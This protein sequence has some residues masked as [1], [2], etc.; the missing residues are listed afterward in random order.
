MKLKFWFQKKYEEQKVFN[1]MTGIIF[2]AE[3][4][5]R[6][7]NVLFYDKT[8]VTAENWG[9]LKADIVCVIEIKDLQVVKESNCIDEYIL[10]NL[11]KQ[12]PKWFCKV[13]NGYII[14]LLG[15]KLNK[16]PYDYDS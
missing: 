5:G 12:N 8:P 1:G 6:C 9:K 4:R 14:N 15:Q 3:I 10:K 11:P 2:D 16:I 7:F 13:E